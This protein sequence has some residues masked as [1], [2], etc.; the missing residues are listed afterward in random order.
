MTCRFRFGV[1]GRGRFFGRDSGLTTCVGG[2]VQ[3]GGFS[4]PRRND[5]LIVDVVKAQN[6]LALNRDKC[7]SGDVPLA[8]EYLGELARKVARL[9]DYSER[10]ICEAVR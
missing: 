7:V 1:G 9:A 6:K 4:R 10:S 2:D 3:L 8:A 5:I